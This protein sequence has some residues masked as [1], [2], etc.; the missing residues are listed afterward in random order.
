MLGFQPKVHKEHKSIFASFFSIWVKILLDSWTW[1]I[2]SLPRISGALNCVQFNCLF[3]KKL[4]QN[5]SCRVCSWTGDH[6][7]LFAPNHWCS[8]LC[9]IQLSVLKE[10]FL[11]PVLSCMFLDSWSCNIVFGPNPWFADLCPIVSFKR[12]FPKMRPDG[13]VTITIIKHLK[14]LL[15]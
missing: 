1:S 14:S 10:P 9:P 12:T 2:N 6:A 11:E 5:E 4:S 15:T 13:Y 8:D 3:R 7:T